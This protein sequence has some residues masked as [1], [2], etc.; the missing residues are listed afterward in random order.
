MKRSRKC[1]WWEFF[2]KPKQILLLIS[3][4]VFVVIII[5]YF[6]SWQ[7]NNR[8][9]KKFWKNDHYYDFNNLMYRDSIDA[10]F[11]GEK[12]VHLDLKGAPPKVSYYEKLFPLLVKLGATGLLIEYEDMF[13]YSGPLLKNVSASNAYS[14][15]D[16]KTILKLAEESRLSVIPLI[17]TFGHMEFM[18]KLKEFED[19]REVIEYPQVICPTH[20]KSLSLIMHMVDEIVKAHPSATKI[21]IG[22]DEVWFVGVCDRCVG[23]LNKFGW[24]K[25]QL[26][27]EHFVG[28]PLIT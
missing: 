4:T 11:E 9:F 16:I 19:L 17:Q 24:T 20:E 22:A 23:I 28:K 21:H 15:E 14:L 26:F 2:T 7:N 3:L 10:K 5:I 27:L 18:L 13:P 12:I 25:S 1:D 8:S 6:L